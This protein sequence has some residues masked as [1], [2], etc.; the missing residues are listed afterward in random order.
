MWPVWIAAR[1][2]TTCL[3]EN[4]WQVLLAIPGGDQASQV[5][6]GDQLVSAV[7]DALGF[8]D[9]TAI[10]PAR[11]LVGQNPDVTVPVIQYEITI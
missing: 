8:A 6:A 7:A 3:T 1:P 2:I 5:D 9:I 10:R 4:D 11:L